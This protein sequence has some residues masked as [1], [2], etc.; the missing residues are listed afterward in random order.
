MTFKTLMGED[1]KGNDELVTNLYHKNQVY[2]RELCDFL[3][4]KNVVPFFGAGFSAAAYPTWSSLLR[5]MAKPYPNCKDNLEYYLTSGEFEEAA[6]ILCQEMGI[7]VFQ[8]ELY[9]IFNSKT[10]SVAI[11][12]FSEARKSVHQIFTGPM[13]TT[14]VDKVLEKLYHH[15]LPVICPHTPYH[16]PRL[17]RDLQAF[18]KILVKLHGDI[19]DFDHAIFTKE[20]Y[21]IVYQNLTNATTISQTLKQIFT[22]R[23]VLFLGCSLANDRVLKVLE[24]YC[25]NHVYYA[26]VELPK[27]TENKTD[28]FAPH[29]R[30][31]KNK[32]QESFRIRRQFMANYHIKCIWYPYG[33]FDTMDAFL[34]ELR[35]QFVVSLKSTSVIPAARRSILGRDQAVDEVFQLCMT[36]DRPVFVT[37][38]GGIGK[39]EV[40][41]MVLKRMEEKGRT[42]LYVNVTDIKEPISW[43]HAMADA[44]GT[45]PISDDMEADLTQYLFY[46]KEKIVVHHQPALYFDN[47]EDFWYALDGQDN[48]RLKLLEWI[49]DLC[50]NNVPVLLSS[51]EYSTEYDVAMAYYPLAALDQASG[52]DRKLFQQIYEEKNGHL[53]LE[54]NAYETLLKQLDGHPLSIVLAATQAAATLSWERI[55][56]QWTSASQKTSNIRHN[57]LQTALKVSWDVV[58]KFPDCIMVWGLIALGY[59]NMTYSTLKDLSDLPVEQQQWEKAVEQLRMASLLDLS[60]NGTELQMLQPIK[61]SFF[62]LATETQ[63]IS[64][65]ERWYQFYLPTLTKANDRKDPEQHAAHVAVITQLPHILSLLERMLEPSLQDRTMDYIIEMIPKMLN[66]FQ[67]ACIQS[68][69]ICN[70]LENLFQNNHNHQNLAIIMKYHGD[71]LRHLGKSNEAIQIYQKTQ[72]L[73]LI[74][75]DNL[76]LANTFLNRGQVLHLIGKLEEA[77]QMY[78]QAQKLFQM[79]HNNLGLANTALNQGDLFRH[80]GKLNEADKM[81]QK[82]CMLYQTEYDDQGLANTLQ[83]KG[84]L[85]CRLGQRNEAE[86]MYQQAQKLFQ[87]LCDTQGLANIALRQGDLLR[88]FGKLEEAEQ[89]Y[90]QAQKIFQIIYDNLGLANT[91]QRRGSLVHLMGKLEEAEQMYQQ[92]QK[93]FQTIHNNQG[94][95]NMLQNRGIILLYLGK[96]DE[97]EQMYQQAQ[98][99]FLQVQDKQAIANMFQLFGNLLHRKGKFN[100]A[101]QMFQTAYKLYQ[102]EQ[103]KLGL[104][105]ILQS[106][107]V[108]KFSS[109]DTVDA[110]KLFQEALS[111]FETE[112]CSYGI[113]RT[114]ALLSRSLTKSQTYDEQS[115]M[116]AQRA[117]QLAETMPSVMKESVLALL[118][119]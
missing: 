6:S 18:N 92:A 111:Y 70:K 115:T 93:L 2:F 71:I 67:F 41:H 81:Y 66:Y 116:L 108:L 21:D 53:A 112:Q 27:E 72:E 73:F 33:Q 75:H 101:K 88:Y 110:I 90:Q 117:R 52:I 45:T 62:L 51:R 77:E 58:S 4:K 31:S 85:L 82:A 55:L 44:V 26:L 48:I 49:A 99:L 40:C 28:P 114:C 104:A 20:Q 22:N 109:G 74:T 102:Q 89:M 38:S 119:L 13:L 64:C 36:R 54:G 98:R 61:E 19:D 12:K 23:I 87:R 14:N 68:L 59:N 35:N 16:Q 84:D 105:N 8:E 76:D 10:L 106:Q 65:I 47:W 60:C 24:K 103:D 94:I 56:E 91:I 80:M 42:I 30:N 5:E 100:D 107:G 39:T 86:Q 17:E 97:A 96:L 1:Y 57:N 79:I 50:H 15:M 95:A 78:Q 118:N 7:H 37:G 43:C 34:L 32:E 63:I 9:N 29:L 25:K 11:P 69:G 83:S 46:I 3:K 113:A